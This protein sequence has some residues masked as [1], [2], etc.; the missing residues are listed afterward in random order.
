[1]TTVPEPPTLARQLVEPVPT[2]IPDAAFVEMAA[3]HVTGTAPTVDSVFW[4]TFQLAV[5][6]AAATAS[7]YGVGRFFA[8]TAVLSVAG[9][10][11]T[12]IGFGSKYWHA[13]P[14]GVVTVNQ[15]PG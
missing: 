6:V 13:T 11:G 5:L 14:G 9:S 10:A 3:T 8:V 1:M 7:A 4:S 12:V 2:A 15:L